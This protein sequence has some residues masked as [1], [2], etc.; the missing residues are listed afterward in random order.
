MKKNY[1]FIAIGKTQ[2]S[3]EAG[4][5]FKRY[6]GIGSSYV[7]AVNPN[8]KKLDELRGFESANEP[9]YIKDTDNGKEAHIN[10]V[11]KTDPETCNGVEMTNLAMF[12]LRQAPAYNKDETKVQVLDNYGNHAWVD[13][14]LAK[15]GN[16][17]PDNLAVDHNKY[18]MACVG[19]CDLVDFLKKYLNVPASLSYV[20]GVWNLSD[21]AADGEFRLEHVKDYFKGDFKELEEAL[22]YQPNN[23]IKL[24]YGVRTTE[25]GKQYQTVC[26]RGEMILRNNAGASSIAKLQKTLADAKN[27]GLFTTTTFKVGE[28]EEF[29]VEPTNL[30]VTPSAVDN[31]GSE[32]DL[33]W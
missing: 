21:N 13:V 18:R 9:E 12:I 10:F 22:A 16:K 31:I 17:L 28:L 30:T 29:T 11:V 2:E 15:S 25:E 7:L 24:L 5:S 19:E 14:D 8:K 27:A 4:E 26:T 3:K 33:P 20:G 23:K 6:I 32:D 1:S